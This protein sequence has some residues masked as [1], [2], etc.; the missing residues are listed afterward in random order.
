MNSRNE[1]AYAAT[2]QQNAAWFPRDAATWVY[3]QPY[4]PQPQYFLN[5]FEVVPYGPYWSSEVPR[6]Q[7]TF[8]GHCKGFA[9][10]LENNCNARNGF[11]PKGSPDGCICQRTDGAKGCYNSHEMYCP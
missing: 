10:R 7:Q 6:S 3:E 4:P 8:Y 1:I 5:P 9:G 11:K 2:L